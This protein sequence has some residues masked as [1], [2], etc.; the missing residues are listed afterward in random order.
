MSQGVRSKYFM[1][2]ANGRIR[3]GRMLFTATQYPAVHGFVEET[4]VRTPIRWTLC[5]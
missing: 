5:F 2:P 3:L 4:L 1:D